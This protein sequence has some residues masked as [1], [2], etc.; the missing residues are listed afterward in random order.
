MEIPVFN[1]LKVAIKRSGLP[2]P[3]LSY[4]SG[5]C[6]STIRDWI[7]GN[8]FFPRV[9][10]MLRVAAVLGQHIELTPTMT[11]M[12]N[13]YPKPEINPPPPIPFAGKRMSRHAVRMA[14]LRAQ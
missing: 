14:L 2:L 1:E 10:T 7:Y 6:Q 3:Y 5:V 4:R 13:Y 11:R 9:D 8:T 12:V